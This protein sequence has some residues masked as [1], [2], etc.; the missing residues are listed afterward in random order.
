[1]LSIVTLLMLTVMRSGT[2]QD[3]SWVSMATVSS[4]ACC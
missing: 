3:A 1:M 4:E 2:S